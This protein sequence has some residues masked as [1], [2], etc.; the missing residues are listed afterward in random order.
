[1][2]GP[3]GQRAAA[4][5]VIGGAMSPN[6][7]AHTLERRAPGSSAFL[8]FHLCLI[9]GNVYDWMMLV[10]AIDLY[11]SRDRKRSVSI[12]IYVLAFEFGYSVLPGFCFYYCLRQHC[13]RGTDCERR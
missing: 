8:C 9:L 1:M 2:I 10:L 5:S 6:H 13:R 12:L 7:A 4:P 3:T 11:N